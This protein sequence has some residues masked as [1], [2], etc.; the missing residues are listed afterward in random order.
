MQALT[1]ADPNRRLAYSVSEACRLL[2]ISRRHLYD[3]LAE[4]RIKSTKLGDRRLIAHAELERLLA[5]QQAEG[6]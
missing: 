3:L 2:S 5:G 6:G 1:V 4:G